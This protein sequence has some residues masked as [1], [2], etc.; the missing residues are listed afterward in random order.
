MEEE[1]TITETTMYHVEALQDGRWREVGLLASLASAQLMK[2]YT[3]TQSLVALPTRIFEV[4]TTT[5]RVVRPVGAIPP[6]PLPAAAPAISGPAAR[7]VAAVLGDRPRMAT[8]DV[9]YVLQARGI[10][11]STRTVRRVRRQMR[12]GAA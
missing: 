11:V 4:I 8:E 9:I 12:L 3:G 5:T 1:G 7:A 2:G 10:E 6:A